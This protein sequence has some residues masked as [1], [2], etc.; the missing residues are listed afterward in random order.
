MGPEYTWVF[1]LPLTTYSLYPEVSDLTR[2]YKNRLVFLSLKNAFIVP[3]P[4]TDSAASSYLKTTKI[5][6][7]TIWQKKLRDYQILNVA[8]LYS[9]TLVCHCEVHRRRH[10]PTLALLQINLTSVFCSPYQKGA[11]LKS[12]TQ[13]LSKSN[14]TKQQWE[15]FARIALACFRRQQKTKAFLLRKF[16]WILRFLAFWL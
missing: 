10:K 4:V 3:K 15:K 12:F 1:A 5:Q 16:P 7:P 14:I 2:V 11:S 13:T 8:V 9:C 6:L